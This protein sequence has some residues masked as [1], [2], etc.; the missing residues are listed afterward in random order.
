[1]LID[2]HCHLDDP[3][4]NHDRDEVIKRADAAGVKYIINIGSD[5]GNSINAVAIAARCPNVYATVGLHP[6]DAKQLD[7]KAFAEFKSL[8]KKPK[9]VAIGE[10]GLDYYRNLSQKQEQQEVFRKF[11]KFADESRLPVIIHARE[12]DKD[13]LKILK[14]HKPQKAVLHCFSAG[15]AML[16]EALGM[17]FYISYTCAVTFKNADNLRRL[18]KATPIERMML[19]TD[20][21]YM[22]PQ[23]YR[24]KRCEPAYVAILAEEV[25]RLKGLSVEDIARITTLNAF[26]FFNIGVKD[27]KKDKQTIAY[28]IRDSLY[29]N[30]TNRCTNKCSFCV[31]NKTDFVKGH[32]LRLTNEPSSGELIKV[33]G[34]PARYK[35]VVFCGYGEPTL[36]FDVVL[37]V[38]KALKAKGG[39]IRVVTNGHA[40]LINKGDIT[41]KLKGIVDELSVSLDVDTKE[42]YNRI[43]QPDFGPDTFDKVKEFVLSAKR[44]IPKIEITCLD[45]Q[46]V[47]IA[48]CKKIAEELGVGFRVRAYNEVG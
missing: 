6:H 42:K 12:A 9:V 2:T 29:L 30:I 11:L 24:G 33:V 34:D 31:R 32:N 35:E 25:A 1:M 5:L 43:C 14:E 21:P 27:D 16:Q 45:M 17:G 4:F 18:V 47:D 23:Q 10:V 40:N 38:S 48:A 7:D 19:E 20:A 3:I 28:K 41:A 15:D 44:H 22:A 36:R 37:E 46:G 39:R 26:N 8:V 13:A